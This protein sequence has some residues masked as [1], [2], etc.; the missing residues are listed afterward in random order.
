MEVMINFLG[1]LIHGMDVT[2]VRAAA[3]RCFLKI[4]PQTFGR[5]SLQRDVLRP[6]KAFTTM[7][8]LFI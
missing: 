3:R 2:S 7:R 4:A 5:S 8:N 6:K 1:V